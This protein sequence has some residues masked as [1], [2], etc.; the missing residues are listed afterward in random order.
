MSLLE[1]NTCKCIGRL[2]PS[3][4]LRERE[5]E[6]E[7]GRSVGCKTTVKEREWTGV[8]ERAAISLSLFLSLIHFLLF[9]RG[10]Q[11]FETDVVD[12][13]SDA[14][15]RECLC[16]WERER[17]R[18]SESLKAHPFKFFFEQKSFDQFFWSVV[19]LESLTREDNVWA[20]KWAA[21]MSGR[22][23]IF[24]PTLVWMDGREGEF[25]VEINF[26]HSKNAPKMHWTEMFSFYPLVAIPHQGPIF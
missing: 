23:Y 7:R 12:D 25:Q 9:H 21:Q 2:L 24:L 1:M 3:E 14:R 19:K 13:D 15:E 22:K 10:G 16:V 6:R 5:K 18:E 4:C 26:F 17:E 11:N 8:R 20:G